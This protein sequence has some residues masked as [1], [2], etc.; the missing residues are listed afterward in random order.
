MSMEQPRRRRRQDRSRGPSQQA[1]VSP[2]TQQAYNAIPHSSGATHATDP[3]RRDERA[4]HLQSNA[5]HRTR[6]PRHGSVT[7]HECHKPREDDQQDQDRRLPP[8]AVTQTSRR[9]LSSDPQPRTDHHVT[10]RRSQRKD[11]G[12]AAQLPVFWSQKRPESQKSTRV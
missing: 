6:A 2:M 12:L 7:R 3:T 8:R 1:A 4:P 11:K 9:R 10:H 5:Q